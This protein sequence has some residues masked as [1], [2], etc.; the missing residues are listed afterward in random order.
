VNWTCLDNDRHVYA[1]VLGSDVVRVEFDGR[2]DR[3]CIEAV[4]TAVRLAQLE[5]GG[6][7]VKELSLGAVPIGGFDRI[8]AADQLASVRHDLTIRIEAES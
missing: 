6:H 4:E 8:G 7:R 3:C 5:A 1:T 2:P